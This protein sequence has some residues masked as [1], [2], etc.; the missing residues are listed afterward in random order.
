[1]ARKLFGLDLQPFDLNGITDIKEKFDLAMSLEV[2]EHLTPDLGDRLV[3]V[4]CAHAPLCVFS[5]AHP[6]QPG[7]GHINLQPKSYWVEWFH[8]N[9]FTLNA[10]SSKQLET[11]LRKNLIRG[12]WLADNVCIFE[13]VKIA[14][15]S[16]PIKV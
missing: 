9:G 6:G 5:A 13:K 8:Q 10:D 7:H 12:L 3:E 14:V 2:G 11:I 16:E 1:M 15:Q 4:C